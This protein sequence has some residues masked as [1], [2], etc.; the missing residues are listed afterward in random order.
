MLLVL[1]LTINEHFITPQP[2]RASTA[3]DNRFTVV[4][5]MTVAAPSSIWPLHEHSHR[6]SGT[7]QPNC[8]AP[9]LFWNGGRRAS[10]AR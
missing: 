9:N 7:Q 4:W 1:L 5:M 2:N 6:L 8:A 3:L 10:P